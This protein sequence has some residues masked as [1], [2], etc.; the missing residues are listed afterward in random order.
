MKR[1]LPKGFVSNLKTGQNAKKEVEKVI[2]YEFEKEVLEGKKK[3]I[4]GLPL[5]KKEL[6]RN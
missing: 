1:R 3:A 5:N 2:P 4:I 6:R